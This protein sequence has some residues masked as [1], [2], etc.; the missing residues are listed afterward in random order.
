MLQRGRRS[1]A[2]REILTLVGRHQQSSEPTL[3]LPE[4]PDHFDAAARETWYNI[5]R[6]NPHLN[7]CGH[8]LLGMAVSA[9][10]Q[11]QHCAE[12]VDKAGGP[13]SNDKRGRPK[14]HPLAGLVVANNKLARDLFKMLKIQLR[15]NE[16]INRASYY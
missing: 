15:E 3:E 14:R 1:K 7:Y 2:S 6:E 9:L 10:H 16:L 8:M 13:L 4:P 11:A 5:V 12:V